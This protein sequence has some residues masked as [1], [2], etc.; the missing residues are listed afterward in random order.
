MAKTLGHINDQ[1]QVGAQHLRLSLFEGAARP[2]PAA[3]SRP[4]REFIRLLQKRGVQGV[5]KRFM[6]ARLQ[7][8]GFAGGNPLM[9]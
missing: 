1:P 8:Q 9:P 5:S 4:Q 3:A 7:P 2:A 6:H